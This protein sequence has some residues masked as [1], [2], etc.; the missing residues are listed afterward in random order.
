M[1]SYIKKLGFLYKTYVLTILTLGYLTSEMGH[2]LIGVT[3]KATARDVHYGDIKCQLLG[4][5]A[6]SDVFNYTLHERCDSSV[7]QKS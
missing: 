2:F 4:H 1:H 7:D 6:E 5:L 3:S